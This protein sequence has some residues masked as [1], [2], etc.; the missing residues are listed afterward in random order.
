MALQLFG[1]SALFQLILLPMGSVYRT[2]TVPEAELSL[3]F[4]R[5][6]CSHNPEVTAHVSQSRSLRECVYP[7]G[8]VRPGTTVGF[9]PGCSTKHDTLVTSRAAISLGIIHPLCL[10][11]EMFCSLEILSLTTS[12]SKHSELIPAYLK[13]PFRFLRQAHI[14]A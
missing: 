10:N 12:V 3:G 13:H 4:L 6:L 5:A 1:L 9:S 7:V 11:Y 14:A 8:T 2:T